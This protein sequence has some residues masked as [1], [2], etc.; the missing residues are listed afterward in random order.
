[1]RHRA[2]QCRLAGPATSFCYSF[3]AMELTPAQITI[4]ERLH[5]RG[6][7]IVAFPMYESAVG[8]RKG[9]CAALLAPAGPNAFTIQGQPTY[10]IGG[11]LSARVVRTDGHYFVRKQEQLEATPK[12]L[13]EL[14]AFTA[15]LTDGL[16]PLA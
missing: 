8:V 2:S 12:R 6:L 3:Y 11:N 5:S 7:E 10:L 16:L 15:E 9:N 4:L 13:A 14:E 1:V